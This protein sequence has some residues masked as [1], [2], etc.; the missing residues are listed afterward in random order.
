M[1]V[2]IFGKPSCANCDKALE[3]AKSYRHNW[4]YKNVTYKKYYDEMISHI[5]HEPEIIP[6]PIIFVN[7]KHVGGY[8]DYLQYIE[9]HLGG[10]GDQPI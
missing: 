3:V 9:D 7:G 8:R 6:L 5:G 1:E 10:F 2:E 4:Q